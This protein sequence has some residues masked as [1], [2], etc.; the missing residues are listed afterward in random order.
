VNTN[1][2]FALLMLMMISR[3][4]YAEGGCPPG[5]YPPNPANT[6]VCYPIPD[7]QQQ[8]PQGYWQNRYAA[9]AIGKTATGSGAVGVSTN[10][11][12]KKKADKAAKSEC[13]NNGGKDC[14]VVMSYYNQCAVLAWGATGSSTATGA[15]IEEVTGRALA[16]C[17]QSHKSCKVYYSNCVEPV[18]IQ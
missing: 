17:S 7:S 15:N 2:I 13:V 4:A 12:S 3:S 10:K 8:K 1:R 18:W 9:I 11:T 6:A 16:D 14:K 5:M